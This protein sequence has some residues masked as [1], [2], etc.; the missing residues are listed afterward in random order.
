MR[1]IGRLREWARTSLPQVNQKAASNSVD[2]GVGFG[3]DWLNSIE[4]L[5]KPY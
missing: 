3:M 4:Q 5:L 1:G 2:I